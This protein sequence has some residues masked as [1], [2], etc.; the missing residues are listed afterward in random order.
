RG[1]VDVVHQIGAGPL[2][3]EVLIRS[4]VRRPLRVR[5][6]DRAVRGRRAGI[7]AGAR[8]LARCHQQLGGGDAAEVGAARLHV[9]G[10]LVQEQR[11]G[12]GRRAHR[13]GGLQQRLI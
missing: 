8:R 10:G 4:G 7:V 1:L 13:G 9:E 6:E 3:R 5:G 2:Q 11:G 12:Q